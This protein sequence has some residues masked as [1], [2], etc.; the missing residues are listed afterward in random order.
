[1]LN[2][3]ALAR[4]VKGGIPEGPLPSA[5]VGVGTCVVELAAAAEL[6]EAVLSVVTG[7]V[8]VV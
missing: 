4:A 2:T 6:A 7:Q 1:M 8:D 3:V 5:G